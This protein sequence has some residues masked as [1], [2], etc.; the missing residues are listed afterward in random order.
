MKIKTDSGVS[1]TFIQEGSSKIMLFDRPVRGIELKEREILQIGALLAS[2]FKTDVELQSCHS[3][4]EKVSKA[5]S[6]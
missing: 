2:S 1:I 6:R 3:H 4:P 5:I